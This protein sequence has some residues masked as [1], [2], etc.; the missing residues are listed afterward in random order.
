MKKSILIL[1]FFLIF[2]INIFARVYYARI[3]KRSLKI[4][5]AQGWKKIRSQK[6]DVFSAVRKN[7]ILGIQISLVKDNYEEYI[8]KQRY[9]LKRIANDIEHDR[10]IYIEGME[11]QEFVVKRIKDKTTTFM[12]YLITKNG[13]AA[14]LFY[15]KS[16]QENIFRRNFDEIT[17]II[18]IFFKNNFFK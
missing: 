10:I 9:N 12:R 4:N 14:I 8:N 18:S 11:F 6:Y 15:Y 1:S 16:T 5:L 2:S 7:E 17:R 13:N 3:G